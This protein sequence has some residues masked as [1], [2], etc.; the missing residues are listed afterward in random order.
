MPPLP[1]A[2]P[3]SL[4]IAFA[5]GGASPRDLP[6]REPRPNDGGSW[7]TL[8]GDLLRSGFYPRFPTGP[9]RERWRKELHR[10]LTGPRAEVIVGEGIASIGTYAGRVYAW[11]AA[12]GAE[13]WVAKVGGPVLHSPA[14]VGGRIFVASMDGTLRA[15][16]VRDGS[17]LWLHRADEGY[18]TSPCVHDGRVLI[19]ARDGVFRAIDASSGRLLWSHPTPAPILTTASIS[20]DGA[21]VVF[22]AED[23]R[24]RALEVA[25]GKRRWRSKQ[26]Q[27]LSVRDH[28]P[29]IAGGVA[30][31][32]TNPV[33][34][35]HEVLGRHQALFLRL[36]GVA[37]EGAARRSGNDP[38]YIEYDEDGFRL[39]QRAFL[40]HLAEH[41]EDQTFWA[42]RLEDGSEPWVAPVAYTAGLHN[43]PSPPCV[44]QD[45]GEVYIFVRSA[46]GEW[47]GG[48]EVRPYTGV[49]KLDVATGRVDL[50]RHG[51]RPD[52][53]G[54]G[55]GRKDMPWGCFW[56]I[57]DE[58]QTLSVSP[59][60]LVSNHQGSIG[61]MDLETGRCRALYGKRDTYGGHYGPGRFGWGEEGRAA[62]HAA[63][64][65]FGLVNE[66][67]GPARAIVSVASGRVYYHVGSQVICLEE[68]R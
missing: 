17:V 2:L 60:L 20:P 34:G 33:D 39:E 52:A 7:P 16:D 38:R 53:Q 11:D 44:R 43:P 37:D 40:A 35:F 62:A 22:A 26:M 29:V 27:G 49:G 63:G 56:S 15:L 58:T 18:W 45:T 41:P 24:A 10:E 5:A 59:R 31:L 64:E 42:L 55:A 4:L 30:I 48:G 36:A 61:A 9:L 54:R 57:G 68:A 12:S 21:L 65:P 23:L 47:D 46:Y 19:G 32:T 14:L 28:F 8:H 3:V 50:V 67:H 1:V 66:W 51:H 13:R 6:T 25:T